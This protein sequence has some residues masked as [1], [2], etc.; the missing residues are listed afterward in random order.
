MKGLCNE[1]FASNRTVIIWRDS[2]EAVCNKCKEK[3]KKALLKKSGRLVCHCHPCPIHNEPHPPL[4]VE[5]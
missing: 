4:E 2:G 3:R 1:C 5:A